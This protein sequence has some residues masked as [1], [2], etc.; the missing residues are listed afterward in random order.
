MPT[1]V[2]MSSSPHPST[3]AFLMAVDGRTLP[4]RSA[5]LTV[6]A[7]GGLAR[8]TVQQLFENPHAEPLRFTYQVPLP[9]DGAV[10]GYAFTI[11]DRRTVGEVD[12]RAR[13]RERFE[14][15]LIQGRTAALLD[16]ERSSV[17]TQELGNVP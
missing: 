11:G 6:E 2:E 15:A 12:R 14:E 7:S 13:A 16:Q 8:V 1:P 4:L 9:A 5:S 17:F 3:G 10:S